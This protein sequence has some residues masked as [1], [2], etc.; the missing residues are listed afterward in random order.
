MALATVP[1]A[2]RRRERRQG[3]ERL[4]A[5]RVRCGLARPDWYRLL[6]VAKEAD[7]FN[8]NGETAP[9]VAARAQLI[10]RKH[11]TFIRSLENAVAREFARPAFVIDDQPLLSTI[12]VARALGVGDFHISTLRDRGRVDATRAGRSWGFSRSAVAALITNEKQLGYHSPLATAFLR[13]LDEE[14][15]GSSAAS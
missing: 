2:H 6:G 5:M 1:L 8:P 9:G 3:R 14:G 10:C 11:R 13:W 7:A 12:Q 4:D 15:V